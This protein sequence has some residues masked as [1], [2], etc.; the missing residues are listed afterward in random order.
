[1]NKKILMILLPA[2]CVACSSKNSADDKTIIVAASSVPHAEILNNIKEDVKKEGYELVV[3]EV[4]DYVTP[5]NALANGEIDLNGFQHRIF[6]ATE[7][8]VVANK[9]ERKEET[10]ME[11]IKV[12]V[13]E[14]EEQ[15]Y[16]W[17][18]S[19]N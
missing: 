12:E 18:H 10:K 9:V 15:N 7:I 11:E 6:F 3:K 4:T 19:Y 13:L 1:M 2:L 17:Q 14:T 16:R 5:N 8:K